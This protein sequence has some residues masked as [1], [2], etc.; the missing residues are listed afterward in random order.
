MQPETAEVIEASAELVPVE[1]A[2][3]LTL[4]GTSDYRVALE[5]MAEVATALVDVIEAKH[6][7]AE[8]NGRRHITCEGWTTLGG[9]L[10]VVPVVVETRANE[11]GDGIVARVEARTLD[12]RVVGAAEGECSRAERRGKSREPFAIRSMAQTR[13]ISRAL[14][15]PLGQIVVLAGYQ[16]AGVEELSEEAPKPPE[17]PAE[18]S[19]AQVAEI[20]A[21]IRSLGEIDPEEDWPGIARGIAGGSPGADLSAGQAET[22]IERLRERLEDYNRAG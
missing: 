6:L 5:R 20:A 11:D 21:L 1:P 10:G 15:A 9:M 2:P 12:G 16:P 19:E 14:R 22:V 18:A 7:Y 4:F 17:R 3:P 8:I 13:A